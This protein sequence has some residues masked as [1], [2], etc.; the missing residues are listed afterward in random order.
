MTSSL[1]PTALLEILQADQAGK[2]ASEDSQSVCTQWRR[3]QNPTFC[4]D[5]FLIFFSSPPIFS[6][7]NFQGQAKPL[8]LVSEHES[9]FSTDCQ[10]FWLKH[11]SFLLMLAS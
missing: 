1:P 5:D 11:I 7:K 10:L 8:L 6:F 3:M 9:T 4:L 2:I